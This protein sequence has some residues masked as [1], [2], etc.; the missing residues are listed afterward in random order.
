MMRY[1]LFLLSFFAI[2]QAMAQSRTISKAKED[3]AQ[4]QFTEGLE[5]LNSL[6]KNANEQALQNYFK[7]YYFCLP[8][9]PSYALDSAYNCVVRSAQ[10]F[11]TLIA[12]LLALTN[13]TQPRTYSNNHLSLPEP[14]AAMMF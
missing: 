14:Y 4:N 5:R 12:R 8:N 2:M 1:F 10:L 13:S 7:A 11:G 6:N 3:F 9:N